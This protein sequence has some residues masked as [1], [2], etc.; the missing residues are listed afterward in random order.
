[1]T[2][3]NR[4]IFRVELGIKEE[5]NQPLNIECH[6]PI[7]MCDLSSAACS[8]S[9]LQN[10]ALFFSSKAPSRDTGLR[11]LRYLNAHLQGF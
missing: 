5:V 7:V 3:F 11:D 4:T 8:S 10:V 9:N 2:T 1:M 6:E